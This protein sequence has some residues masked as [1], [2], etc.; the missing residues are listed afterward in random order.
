MKCNVVRDLLASYNDD[1]LE[2]ETRKEVEEHLAECE[3]CRKL[4]ETYSAEFTAKSDEPT[5]TAGI[6]PFKKIKRKM[7]KIKVRAVIAVL[8]AS[9]MAVGAGILTVGQVIKN[10]IPSW[11][12][13]FQTIEVRKAA[14]NLISGDIEGFYKYL[15]KDLPIDYDFKLAFRPDGMSENSFPMVMYDSE[16]TVDNYIIDALKESYEKDV[17]G[18]DIRIQGIDTGY[19]SVGE[20]TQLLTVVYI[21]LDDDLIELD[22]YD[23][24]SSKYDFIASI[25]TGEEDDAHIADVYEMDDFEKDCC[26]IEWLI[27]DSDA[28]TVFS[29]A[30]MTYSKYELTFPDD[31]KYASD[32]NEHPISYKSRYIDMLNAIKDKGVEYGQCE[33]GIVWYDPDSQRFAKSWLVELKYR[34]KKAIIRFSAEYT[35]DGNFVLTDTIDTINDGIPDDILNDFYS[36]L[37][38][39]GK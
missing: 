24:G 30:F 2:E 10:H 25:S 4:N 39:I 9:M 6:K 23:K 19:I 5:E 33:N 18:H 22:F 21:E 35:P 31:D 16:K 28:D 38:Y 14:K 1:M 36:A 8:A 17:R 37:N 32:P 12:S 29:Q 34:D 13:V 15:Y 20:V 3:E 11:E 27:D 7:K 26:F